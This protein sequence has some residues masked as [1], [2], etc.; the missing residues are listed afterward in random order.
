METIR[1][2]AVGVSHFSTPYWQKKGN[3]VHETIAPKYLPCRTLMPAGKQ[4]HPVVL[5]ATVP[6]W[7]LSF[8]HLAACD[9]AENGV[10]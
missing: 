3:N 9:H 8:L 1:I 5:Y 4:H 6:P 7:G 10:P 2:R